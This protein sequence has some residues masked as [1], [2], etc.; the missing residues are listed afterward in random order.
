MF[1]G[2]AHTEARHIVMMVSVEIHPIDILTW[3]H[4]PV[5]LKEES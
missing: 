1:V 2:L 4:E 3:W 5:D